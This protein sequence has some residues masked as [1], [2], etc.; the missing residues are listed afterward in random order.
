MGE[1]PIGWV[2]HCKVCG[3]THL[4]EKL[5]PCNGDHLY[6]PFHD[7]LCPIDNKIK[8]YHASNFTLVDRKTEWKRQSFYKKDA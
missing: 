4:V 2:F 5:G 8:T 1:K 7:I 6:F 3:R